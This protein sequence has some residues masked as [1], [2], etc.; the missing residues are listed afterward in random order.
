MAMVCSLE[1]YGVTHN[2][3]KATILSEELELAIEDFL[4][5][6]KSPSRK[7]NEIDNRGSHFYLALYWSNRLK[8]QNDDA[9]LKAYFSSIH[10]DLSENEAKISNELL[11]VQGTPM[12]M[13]GYYAPDDD[14]AEVAMRPSKTLNALLESLVSI[15]V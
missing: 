10:K 3:K 7:V 2:N 6:R 12:D 15:D 9:D 8:N 4:D 1:H 5:N 13:G 14:K 11:E